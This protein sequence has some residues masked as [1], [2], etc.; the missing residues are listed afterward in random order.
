MEVTAKMTDGANAIAAAKISKDQLEKK[1]EKIAKSVAKDAKVDGFRAGKVPM[2]VVM[3]RFGD[4]IQQDAEQEALQGLLDESLKTLEK[5]Q[6]NIVGEPQ[7]SKFERA[8]DGLDVE[9][10]IS[11]RPEVVVEG[12][13]ACIPEYA[14]PKVTKKEIGERVEKLLEMVAP[15]KKI[16]E[17]R[18]LEKGDTA[19]FDF[20]GF[21]DGE[22]FEGGKA[23]GYL[24]DIGSNQFIPGFEEGMVGLKAGEARDVVVNFPAEYGAKHLA[25]KEAVFK[26]K[27]HEIQG[28]VVSKT[29]D[30]ETLKRLLPGEENVTVEVLEQRIKDQIKNEKISKLIGDELKPKF[31]EAVVEKL[32][33]DLPENI[34]EQEIDLQFR[35][36]WQN[37][38]EEEL[39]EFRSNPDK[40]Q[41]KRETFRAEATKSVKLTFIVDE[42]AKINDISV[43]DQEVLQTLY[44][45]AMQQGQ[46]PKQYVE[47]YKNQGVLPAVKMAMIED[48]LFTKLFDKESKAK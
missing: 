29:P 13:E 21:I 34:V 24:L 6:K 27:L 14:T 32:V 40:V 43:A 45:E 44:Y 33:F 8:E 7:V 25:G 22:A 46:D 9:I 31:I 18:G 1:Q 3:K 4:K 48:K 2:A 47:M 5:D 15:L 28:K 36:Q 39:E 19:L 30:E 17:D 38:T 10:K 20:E 35:S 11:F 41:E 23:E 12:Y 42:L 37:F 26:V 16:D